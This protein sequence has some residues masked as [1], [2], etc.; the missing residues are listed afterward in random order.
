[1]YFCLEILGESS[2]HK[3]LVQSGWSGRPY[4]FRYNPPTQSHVR[5]YRRIG[6]YLAERVD[7]HKAANV[8]PL[9]GNLLPLELLEP[10]VFTEP[11]EI[12]PAA[13]LEQKK[14][15]EQGQELARRRASNHRKKEV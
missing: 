8:W 7:V 11:A 3:Y 2:Y 13:A 14:E 1:M 5:A 4:I 15:P 12:E 9:L 6:D 10:H